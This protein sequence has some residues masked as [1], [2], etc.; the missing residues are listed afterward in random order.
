MN[1]RIVSYMAYHPIRTQRGLEILTGLVPWMVVVGLVAG[2]FFIPETI[3]YLI[4]AFNVYWLYRSLQMVVNA[5][6]G[7]LN[8]RATEQIDWMS[9]LKSEQLTKSK[10]RKIFHVVIIPN[11][12]E[13]LSILERNLDSLSR[14]NFSLANLVIVLAMEDR[15]E[16]VHERAEILLKKY[17]NKFGKILATFHPIAPGETIGKHSNETFA[18]KAVKE[19]L[20][21]KM[22]VPIK[23]ITIT[24]SDVDCVFPN[25]YFSLLT[26][27]FLTVRHPFNSF[28]QAPLFMYNNLHRLPLLVRVPSIVGGIHYLSMLRKATGRFMNFSTYSLSLA[29]LDKVGYWDVDV[30]PEDWHL[31][32]KSYFAL[33]GKVEI[34]QLYLPVFI[35]AAE[36]TSKWKTYRNNYE[37][38]KRWAWG[39]VDVPYVVKKFF[40]HPE[41]PVWDKFQKLSLTLEWHF[42][43]SSSWLLIT[44]GATIPTIVNPVFGRTTLGYNLSR[45]S[46]GI[47]TLCL[48]GIL[49]ITVLDVLLNSN[50]KNRLRTL[51]HPITY[52]QWLLLPVAG[53]IF[54]ALPGLESQTRL[55]LGKY[56]DYRVTEKV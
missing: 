41:I 23:N 31:N 36:S 54:G 22:K 29:M 28:F 1:D 45:V 7:Y 30:I 2:S 51:L 46:S 32:L 42:V 4:L 18:A 44:L 17:K 5:I 47:L 55:M 13:P 16:G 14:Q 9:R 56:I 3:A 43:W 48:A 35:D 15:V 19:M 27:R 37:Q 53:F 10:F 21:G 34:A 6:S 12:K 49:T 26:Y 24:T 20:V 33:K 52:L 39:V 11:V 38:V 8:I 40:Q 50:R 25:Q